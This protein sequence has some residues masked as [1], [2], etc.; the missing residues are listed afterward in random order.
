[1]NCRICYSNTVRELG[2]AEFY[3]GYSWEIYECDECGCRFT[4]YEPEVYDALHANEHSRYG[5]YQSI[6]RQCQQLFTARDLSGLRSHLCVASKSR[7]VIGEV[8]KRPDVKRVLEI[9]CSRGYLTS[10]FILAGYDIEGIDLSP[11]AVNAANN[12]FGDHFRLATPEAIQQRN[13]CDAIYHVGMIGCVEDPSEYTHRMLAVLKPGG[14]LLFNAPNV[15]ACWMDGQLWLDSAPPPDVVTLY[16]KGF[17]TKRF[18]HIA[19]VE[20]HVEFH[21]PEMALALQ[22]KRWRHSAWKKPRPE[23][24]IRSAPS[25]GG[26]MCKPRPVGRQLVSRLSLSLRKFA[27]LVGT[28]RLV[29]PFPTDFG[30]FVKMTKN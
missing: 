17:W 4:R 1:M 19:D 12:A 2:T 22:I 28:A 21:P 13:P 7:F 5:G 24:L 14:I 16:R 10:F 18:A 25:T 6:A 9:G 8:Q 30:L 29:A 11:E 26:D 15:E 20:E 3:Q 27:A 23:P